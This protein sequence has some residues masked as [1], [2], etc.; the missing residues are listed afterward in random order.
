MHRLVH[1]QRPI[2][3]IPHLA[4][5]LQRDVNDSFGP[6]K[7]NHLWV[8]RMRSRLEGGERV[9]EQYN[10]IQCCV[11]R[12]F[13]FYFCV[14][15]QRAFPGHCHSRGA[16]DRFLCFFFYWCLQCRIYSKTTIFHIFSPPSVFERSASLP[17]HYNP[18]S[19][20]VSPAKVKSA[21]KVRSTFQLE[22]W[23]GPEQSN[24][25]TFFFFFLVIKLLNFFFLKINN[26][27]RS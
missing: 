2:L 16:R 17:A 7:E 9:E 22:V 20:I 15:I 19:Q 14:V 21:I 11:V 5:H 3:R 18:N 24:F 10:T 26:S 13:S 27:F 8:C 23:H 4:I 6:N 12:S 1:V 25:R